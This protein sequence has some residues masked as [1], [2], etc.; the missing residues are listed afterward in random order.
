MK[1]HGTTCCETK[2]AH[3]NS[4]HFRFII[5]IYLVY[6]FKSFVS[7]VFIPRSSY[8]YEVQSIR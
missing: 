4:T 6:F 3:K 5:I 1:L 8:K 2:K 7:Q